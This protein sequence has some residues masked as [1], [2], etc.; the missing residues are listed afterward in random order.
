M[1]ARRSQL[2]VGTVRHRRSRR[3]HYDF[4]HRVWYVAIAL[5]E[6]PDLGL[7]LLSVNRPNVC[8]LNDRDHVSPP[9]TSIVADVQERLRAHGM[10]WDE[11]R[12]TLITYPRTLGYV[13]NPV[14]FFL[15]HDAD[16]VLRL[17]IAEVGAD[18]SIRPIEEAS[19]GVL[20]GRDTFSTGVIRSATID[21]ALGALEGFSHLLKNYG[22]TRVRAVATDSLG[23]QSVSSTRTVFV[24]TVV[25]TTSVSDLL[26]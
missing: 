4:T 26:S 8:S 14:S 17:V 18:G 11:H 23:N 13:F 20:L 1:N 9:G 7:R 6:L 25:P 24:D 15:V 3:L 5:E 21:S 22:V 2:L 10:A 16:Q 19:R 12:V